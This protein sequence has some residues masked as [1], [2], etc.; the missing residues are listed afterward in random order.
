MV[1]AFIFVVLFYKPFI[2]IYSFSLLIFIN[3]ILFYSFS[4][5]LFA[6]ICF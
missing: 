3:L 1:M 4:F 5:S 2:S 6:F